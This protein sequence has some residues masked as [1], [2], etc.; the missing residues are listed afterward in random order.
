MIF[1][2][3]KFKKYNNLTRLYIVLLNIFDIPLL[4]KMYGGILHKRNTVKSDII[5]NVAVYLF[6]LM[7][8]HFF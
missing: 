2:L 6:T 1:R 5:V 4:H 7:T 3:V 8:F